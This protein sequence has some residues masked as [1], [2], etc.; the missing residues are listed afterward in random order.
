MDFSTC[1]NIF[2]GEQLVQSSHRN[3]F[4]EVLGYKLWEGLFNRI[5][6]DGPTQANGSDIGVFYHWK[7]LGIKLLLCFSYLILGHRACILCFTISWFQINFQH[8]ISPGHR[9]VLQKLLLFLSASPSTVGIDF[10]FCQKT[11]GLSPTWQVAQFCYL[12]SVW[13]LASLSGWFLTECYFPNASWYRLLSNC[14]LD[15]AIFLNGKG[16][17]QYLACGKHG[18]THL[19]C[20]ALLWSLGTNN[21]QQLHPVKHSV[22]TL[23]LMP[24]VEEKKFADVFWGNDKTC[25]SSCMLWNR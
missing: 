5:L 10:P 24:L 21:A 16:Y 1:I 6:I 22:S 7:L 14:L 13:H 17:W 15:S 2:L 4:G 25:S 8:L 12:L 19:P 23:L 20:V 18:S 9:S 11:R 3:A